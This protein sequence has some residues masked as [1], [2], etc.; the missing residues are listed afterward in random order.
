MCVVGWL[1]V[2]VVD[3]GKFDQYKR[4][5]VNHLQGRKHCSATRICGGTLLSFDLFYNAFGISF[6]RMAQRH[7]QH[8]K[9]CLCR[10][11]LGP[12]AISAC[13]HVLHDVCGQKIRTNDTPCVPHL[14]RSICANISIHRGG[15]LPITRLQGLLCRSPRSR[16]LHRARTVTTL[17][18]RFYKVSFTSLTRL[19]G[20]TLSQGMLQCGHIGAGAP[21]DIRILSAT[22]RVVRQLHGDRPSHPSYPS[23]L[24]SVLSNSGGHGSRKTCHRCRDTLH[25]FGGYLGSLTQTLHLGSPIASCALHRS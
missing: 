15:T 2:R 8:C 23:C 19:R 11:K 16:H 3:G 22:G 21:V 7:L 10:Y 13:V 25:Q 9:R 24:F 1:I 4:V 6:E 18:F 20:S 17:V 14:F 12:G 5:C